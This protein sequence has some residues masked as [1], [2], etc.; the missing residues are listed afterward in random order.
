MSDLGP[1]DID[2]ATV[3]TG[4]VS[5]VTLDGDYQAVEVTNRDG[6]GELWFTVD[7]SD[8]TVEGAGVFCIV[9]A[10]GA[11][12]TVRSPKATATVVKLLASGAATKA[13]VTGL[14]P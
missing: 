2:Y 8:P 7:G 11:G 10:I 3:A 14:R 9:K 12:I 4:A 6:A 13:I 1:G 5:T